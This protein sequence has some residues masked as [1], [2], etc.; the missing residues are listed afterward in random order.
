MNSSQPSR[1]S[2]PSLQKP[3][4]A[5][6]QDYMSPAEKMEAAVA[7]QQKWSQVAAK[8]GLSPQ[9]RA[10]AL[11]AAQ[12]A[13]AEIVLRQRAADYQASQP[14]MSDLTADPDLTRLLQ[15]PSSGSSPSTNDS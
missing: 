4:P 1:P 8:P 3:G 6:R 15:L 12:S 9:A 11:G 5:P 7:D 14:Q 10:W 2:K 13:Q